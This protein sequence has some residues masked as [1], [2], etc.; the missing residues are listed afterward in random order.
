MRLM[1]W[2]AGE[3]N[4]KAKEVW[5]GSRSKMTWQLEFEVE[6]ALWSWFGVACR[7]DEATWVSET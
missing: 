2:R 1:A 7:I 3:R 6:V 5:G 4:L